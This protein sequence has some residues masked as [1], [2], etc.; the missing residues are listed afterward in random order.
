MYIYAY[1]GDEAA[2]A[3]RGTRNKIENATA[4]GVRNMYF[5][6][7]FFFMVLGASAKTCFS[8]RD[9]G[10]LGAPGRFPN[11]PNSLVVPRL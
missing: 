3:C 6:K 7:F 11:N 1:S 2:V 9:D 10:M 4:S 8:P 5:F